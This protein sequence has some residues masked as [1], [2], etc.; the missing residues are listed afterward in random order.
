MAVR[1]RSRQRVEFGDFQT[2][3]SLA[4]QV[5]EL[6][7]SE[8]PSPAGILEPTCGRGSLLAAAL[9][10]FPSV[11]AAIGIEINPAHAEA[12]RLD[13][14]GQESQAVCDILEQDFF[15]TDWREVLKRLPDPLLV[16]GNP[17]WVTNSALGAFA[18]SNLPVKSNRHGRTGMEALTGKSNFDIS[19]W[20]L[21]RLLDALHGR[22]ALLAMLCKTAVARKVLQYG[23]ERGLVARAEIR[24]IDAREHFAAA[25]DACLLVCDLSPGPAQEEAD[26]YAELTSSLPAHRIGLRDG[27]LVAELPA[28]EQMLAFAGERGPVR[29][30]SGIK[31]DCA[32]VMEFQKVGNWFVNGLGETV[33]LEEEYLYPMLK[34]SDLASGTAT[35]G[36]RWM[37]VTQRAV[38]DDTHHIADDAPRVWQYLQRH[39]ERL[40]RRG[41]SIYRG[42]P[43]FS[44]FGVGPYT[45]APWKVAVSGLYKHLTFRCVG[46]HADRPPVFDD[47][48]A[49]APCHSAAAAEFL[50]RLLSSDAAQTFYRAR[51]FWDTKRPITTEVLNQLHVGRLAEALAPGDAVTAQWLRESCAAGA[52]QLQLF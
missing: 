38:G 33:E 31:H 19:E 37:L 22:H 26:V 24:S 35:V 49:F 46:P 4:R 39:A 23:W 27:R 47:T 16:I 3:P 7:R 45:F 30:R 41:S 17:P 6:L 32:K 18:G 2:P 52:G 40:D 5:C 51:I 42:R 20:M 50:C 25:V 11:R 13:L 34:S 12:A 29:W 14:G 9:R 21:D 15:E 10:Q 8:R 1:T 48:C 28:Y 44:V 43:R 36:A